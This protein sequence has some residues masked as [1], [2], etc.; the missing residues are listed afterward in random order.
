M[1]ET[2]EKKVKRAKEK[3]E[4]NENVYSVGHVTKVAP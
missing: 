3:I 2:V 1:N 4:N